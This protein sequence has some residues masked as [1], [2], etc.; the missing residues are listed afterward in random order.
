MGRARHRALNLGLV[1]GVVMAV[2]ERWRAEAIATLDLRHVGAV[3]LKSACR[4]LPR[5]A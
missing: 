3:K 5:D 1:D 4:L 2:A